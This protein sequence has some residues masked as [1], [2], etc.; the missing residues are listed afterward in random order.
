MPRKI[1]LP[2]QSEDASINHGIAADP[3]TPELG[4]AFFAVA[5]PA[6]DVFPG[7][8][9]AAEVQ[10]TLRLDH[11]V[12]DGLRASGPGWQARANQALRRVLA[13]P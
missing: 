7:A 4:A 13:K 9:D 11:D 10:G 1:G 6:Q 5:R 12:V 2:T 8:R 3:D